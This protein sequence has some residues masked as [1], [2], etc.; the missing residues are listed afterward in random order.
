[1]ADDFPI[2]NIFLY[3]YKFCSFESNN[4]NYLFYLNNDKFRQ[5]VV[6]SIHQVALTIADCCV[7][8]D[9]WW[10]YVG[11]GKINKQA[12]IQRAAARPN[13]M[14]GQCLTNFI[15]KNYIFKAKL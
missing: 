4:V 1:M 2:S 7:K 10:M 6:I 8:K 9:T 5:N 12:R 15:Q 11:Y 13:L 3:L 14:Y